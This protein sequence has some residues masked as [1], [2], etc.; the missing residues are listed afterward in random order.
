MPG[1]LDNLQGVATNLIKDFGKLSTFRAVARTF[2]A[3]TGK[4]TETTT[5]TSVYATPPEPFK[6]FR[7]DGDA[8]RTTDLSTL[9]RGKGLSPQQGDRFVYNGV[10]YQIVAV[11]PQFAGTVIAFYELQ[12]RA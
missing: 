1:K 3:T 2:S 7:V 10:E 5:D 4:T 9:I 12:L 11:W 6:K 8:I